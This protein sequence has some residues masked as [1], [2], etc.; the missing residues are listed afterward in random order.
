MHLVTFCAIRGYHERNFSLNMYLT[1][2]CKVLVVWKRDFTSEHANLHGDASKMWQLS[3]KMKW[4]VM[5]LG[6]LFAGC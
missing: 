2:T 3:M 4:N 5:T 6:D 1:Q